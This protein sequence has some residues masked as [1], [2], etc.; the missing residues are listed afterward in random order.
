MNYLDEYM[1]WINNSYFDEETR[2]EL[3]LIKDDQK[4][5]EDRFYTR[6]QFGTAGLRGIIG[7]GINRMNKYVVR[8][9]TQGVAD[10]L[11]R[12]PG[13][14][15]AV[16]GYDSRHKSV[17]FA[18]E[19]A[20]VLAANNI[21]VYLFEK[22]KPVPIVSYSIRELNADAGV[23]ITA[24]HNPGSY[25]GYKVYGS[26]G[27]Q[28]LPD[29]SDLLL[30]DIGKIDDFSM[31][32]TMDKDEALNKGLLIMLDDSIENR[33]IDTIK[34]YAVNPESEKNLKVVYTPLFGS[35]ARPVSKILNETGFSD[36]VMVKEQEMPD[37]DFP[38][39]KYP[40]PEDPDVFEIALKYAKGE[41][42]DLVIGTDPDADRVGVLVKNRRGEFKGLTG[43]D[44]GCLMLYYLMNVKYKDSF[45]NKGFIVKTIVT[46]KLASIIARSFGLVSI[47][48]LTGFKFI[49]E[50]IHQFDDSKKMKFI[51]GFEESYGYLIGNYARDK[52]SVSAV[53]IIAEMADYY[54][55]LNMTLMDVLDKIHITYGYN[56]VDVISYSL[57]GKEGMKKM[58]D[59]MNG[60]RENGIKNIELLNKIDY[61]KDE[62]Y[63]FESGKISTTG[64]PKSNV[65]YYELKDGSWFCIRP[66]G[67]EPK[68]KIYFEAFS[69]DRELSRRKLIE[70][71]EKVL[72]NI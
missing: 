1:K 72:A 55:K 8:K 15:T 62:V 36:F 4:E 20:L 18:L 10:Y 56:E 5:I 30:E 13:Q 42:A 40:N 48:V 22:L 44:I 21:K 68:I 33:Y 34:T 64:L 67:T 58:N 35:G 51:L 31:V 70:I 32:K 50:K 60:L 37:G 71:K 52:D 45:K 49:A 43:N 11:N 19:T 54:K 46:T 24:S 12:K 39:I 25:N 6:L 16:I 26:Y 57:E 41:D 66:S 63:N 17:E 38:G 65:L 27:A 9:A 69:P 3:L 7:A 2:Q 23:I 47:D 59:I 29:E 61:L 14:K 53:M 28:L